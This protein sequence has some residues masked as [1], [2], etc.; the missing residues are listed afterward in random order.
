M[1]YT[2]TDWQLA[3]NVTDVQ[4]SMCC[5]KESNSNIESKYTCMSRK[6]THK[7]SMK[8]KMAIHV[9]QCTE[10]PNFNPCKKKG[11]NKSSQQQHLQ[12]FS[13]WRRA[14]WPKNRTISRTCMY[15]KRNV[16]N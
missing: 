4:Q 9:L 13:E 5:S 12:A 3:I 7:N 14:M 11:N 16:K 15:M 10:M 1:Q 6:Y 2:N 8:S